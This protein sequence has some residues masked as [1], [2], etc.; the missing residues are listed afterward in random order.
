MS[1]TLRRNRL[2][3]LLAAVAVV[4]GLC[5][6]AS[7]DLG[8]RPS[9]SCHHCDWTM[10]FTGVAGSAPHPVALA[11]PLLA[12]WLMPLVSAAAPR[13]ARKL[14]AHPPRGP[15]PTLSIA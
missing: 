2:I 14:R 7:H 12:A 4:W 1:P 9:Q 8:G 5:G 13:S 11:R 15:P 10:H 3:A 6:Y